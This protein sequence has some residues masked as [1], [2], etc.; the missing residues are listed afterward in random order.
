MAYDIDAIKQSLD[1]KLEGSENCSLVSAIIKKNK[2]VDFYSVNFFSDNVS[3]SGLNNLS[4]QESFDVVDL[5]TEY[6]KSKGY[7]CRVQIGELSPEFK[8]EKLG[9]K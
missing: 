7:S 5:A 4:E 9:I 8:A 3:R 1:E 6:L 2:D